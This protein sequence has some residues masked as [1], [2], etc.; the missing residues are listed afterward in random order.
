MTSRFA[1][2]LG[3]L[4]P[5]GSAGISDEARAL[6]ASALIVDLHCDLLLTSY[7]LKWNWSARH[8][9]NPLPGA[10]LM[11]HVDLPRLQSGNVGCL[12]L[13]VV[14]NP[15]RWSGGPDAIL[16]DLEQMQSEIAKRPD[17]LALAESA[18]AVTAARTAGR[19]ACYG[20]LEGAHGLHGRTDDLPRLRAAGL[21]SVG[22][23]HF[24]ANAACRPMVGWGA[25]NAA[26]L[27]PH[28]CELVDALQDLDL[29]VDLAHVGRTAALDAC[30]RARRPVVIS[31]TACTAVWPSPRGVDDGVVRAV[32][33]TGGVV[34]VI[35]VAPFIGPGG[36]AQVVRH[37]EHL[38]RTVGVKHA[39]VGTDWE[40]FALYPSDL[41]SAD[42]LPALTQALLDAGW[43][44]DDILDVYGRNFLRVY[45]AAVG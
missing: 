9:P 12:G 39:A 4:S 13:G 26:S 38:R 44:H 15:L 42:Q 20:A 30:G 24:T 22:L 23:A 36:I 10:P 25:N 27:L 19:L 31:H 11:G 1:L 17:A 6:H 34:G 45:G 43:P 21:R 33:D 28:G 37:L 41:C 40:G 5:M 8:A 14:T 16:R 2:P 32:A 7:F 18:T 35:F 29:L 3:P